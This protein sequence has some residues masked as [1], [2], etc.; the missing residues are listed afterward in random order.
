[1]EFERN[2][3]AMS[4]RVVELEAALSQEKT[5]RQRLESRVRTTERKGDEA[6]RKLKELERENQTLTL[7]VCNWV[8][9]VEG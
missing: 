2:Y 7:K 1:M 5:T 8:F 6:A 3:N 4:G 9:G